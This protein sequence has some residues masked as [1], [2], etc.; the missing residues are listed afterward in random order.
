[1]ASKAHYSLAG[2]LLGALVVVPA[3]TLPEVARAS[4]VATGFDATQITACDDCYTGAVNLGFSADFFGTT[5]TQAYVSNNGYLTFNSG[6]GTY[7]PTG[8]TASYSGQPIIA[9]FYG[10]VDTRGAGSGL[11]AY[12]TGTYAGHSAFGATWPLVG[13]YS[14][15][16]DKLNTFQVIL[17]NR[18]DT[19][20]GNFDIYFNYT[21]IQ[22]ETGD[23]SGGANGLGGTSAAVGYANGS[24]AAGTYGQIAGSLVPGTFLDSGT[25]PLITTTN[26]GVPGQ[27][28]FQVRNGGVAPPPTGVPEPGAVVVLATALA[29]LGAVRFGASSR[30]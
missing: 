1:M 26:D 19:G 29:A 15:H 13:Y 12:G 27:L 22:W 5:Y 21:Q 17:V 7:T 9:P 16:A 14:S 10:D 3:L 18:S 23:V 24:G 28:L 4:P 25:A 30:R 2:W 8:L 6:Q 20:V 11:T